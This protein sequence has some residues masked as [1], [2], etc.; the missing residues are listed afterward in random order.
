MK[1]TIISAALAMLAGC[2]TVS[3]QPQA[4]GQE[5][6][7][8]HL[9]IGMMSLSIV[10]T[11][12]VITV[13]AAG[14][15][16]QADPAYRLSSRIHRGTISDDTTTIRVD[17]KTNLLTTVSVSSV[18]RLDDILTTAASTFGAIQGGDASEG[19]V[20]FRK[21]Y[22]LD[23]LDTASSDA[24]AWLRNYHGRLCVNGA[25][26]RGVEAENQSLQRL[27][28]D[29]HQLFATSSPIALRVENAPAT[30]ATNR[31]DLNACQ[32]G[33][34]YRPLV[35]YRVT[36]TLGTVSE[37]SETMLFPDENQLMA[38]SL[39]SGVFADQK[40]DLAFVDGVLTSYGQTSQSE[41]L[42]LLSLPI[43]IAKAIIAAPAQ[44][45]GARQAAATA[46]Q[47]YLATIAARAQQLQ[48]TRAVC[49]QTP[50]DCPGTALRVI[51]ASASRSTANSAP[52]DE[53]G[54]FEKK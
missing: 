51:G 28:R 32:R 13:F 33:V 34:C 47:T 26:R 21:L 50:N 49:T 6:I 38:V 40:Y 45:F 10:D 42:G 11:G 9:P 43:D 7:S 15:V 41:L 29:L 4:T 5:G 37:Q 52:R 31:L 39:P 8:Y 19:R 27:C 12:G 1:R 35:P 48:A 46:E 14:P 22:R 23:E 44:L 20:V 24:N 17:E 30:H 54:E 53:S 2:A 3:T 36:L 16:M 18:G 25:I